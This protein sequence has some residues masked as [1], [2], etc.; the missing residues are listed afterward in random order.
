MGVLFTL[1]AS[2]LPSTS[3]SPAQRTRQCQRLPTRKWHLLRTGRI[4]C[5]HPVQL[6]HVL[7]HV[8]AKLRIDLFN[9]RQ[10]G[11][12]HLRQRQYVTRQLSEVN[13]R[14]QKRR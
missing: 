4:A 11:R 2:N 6:G 8:K 7:P 3:K 9:I 10:L 12:G 1:Q 13:I 14:G 5:G